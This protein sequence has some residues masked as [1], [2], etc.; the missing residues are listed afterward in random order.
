MLLLRD[1]NFGFSLIS[2]CSS[3][4][5]FTTRRINLVNHITYIFKEHKN[6][7]IVSASRLKII[8]KRAI[9]PWDEPCAVGASARSGPN[10]F[11]RHDFHN[12]S[13]KIAYETTNDNTATIKFNSFIFL[14]RLK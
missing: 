9:H 2:N 13:T 1:I 4:L 5:V 7:E 8:S 3:L 6:M 14:L 11:S 10:G 12:K